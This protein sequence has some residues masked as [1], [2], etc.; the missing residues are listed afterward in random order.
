MSALAAD[1]RDRSAGSGQPGV[2]RR[3]GSFRSGIG[4][5][6]LVTFAA[7][8]P[9][10]FAAPFSDSFA[11]N[12]LNPGWTVVTANPADSAVLTGANQLQIAAS[13]LNGGSDLYGGSNFNAPVILQS[14]DPSLDW[15]I[16]T[17]VA[18]NPT[19]NYQGAGIILG[20][21][22][23]PFTSY[24]QFSR[25]AQR[26]F[27]PSDGGNAVENEPSSEYISFTGTT[28]WLQVQK[29]GDTYTTYASADGNVWT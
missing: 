10:S 21:T 20:T 8:A 17:V 1:Y 19:S 3:S 27:Y 23:S 11:G 15:T 22:T 4:I 12:T 18:F 29:I 28:T 26:E 2:V 7:M 14:I 9:V 5:A 6:G 25:V 24:G 16:E 13:P